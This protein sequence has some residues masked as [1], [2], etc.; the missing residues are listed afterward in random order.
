MFCH[1]Y[2]KTGKIRVN[3]L[4]KLLELFP[5]KPW[6]WNEKLPT[7][8]N[9]TC[10]IIE[11]YLNKWDWYWLSENPNITWEIVNKYPSYPWDWELL[12][13][14]PSVVTWE[15]VEKHPSYPWDWNGLSMNPN[16]TC[17]IIEK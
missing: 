1:N 6:D 4:K 8:P 16:V 14:N 5:D 13:M 11:K 17:E 15:I 9:V 2:Y 10:E 7:N 12:S 3:H